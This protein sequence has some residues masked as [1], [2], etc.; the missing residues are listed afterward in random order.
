MRA[1]ILILLLTLLPTSFAGAEEEEEAPR[2]PLNYFCRGTVLRVQ[3]GRVT[4]HYDFTDPRELEDF[5]DVR[6]DGLFL[7]DPQ[8]ARIHQGRLRFERFGALRHKLESTGRIDAQFT[9]RTWQEGCVGSAL[10][11]PDRY[12][13]T[14]VWDSRFGEDSAL[15]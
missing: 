5:E 12:T 11:G 1:G 4:L 8:K 15:R 13:L 2:Q 10:L 7:K 3:R 9:V 6:P 14:T